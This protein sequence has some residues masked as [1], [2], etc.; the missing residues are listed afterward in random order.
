[1]Q[2]YKDSASDVGSHSRDTTKLIVDEFEF[3]RQK[4]I[5][6]LTYIINNYIRVST[7]DMSYSMYI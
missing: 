3:L 5:N 2:W 1:M 6:N 7:S 4:S